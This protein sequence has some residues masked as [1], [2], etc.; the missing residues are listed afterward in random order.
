MLEVPT[1]TFFDQ[2]CR[3]CLNIQTV[4]A[5]KCTCCSFNS[6][7]PGRLGGSHVKA[8]KERKVGLRGFMGS[9]ECSICL[10]PWSHFLI[11]MSE[12]HGVSTLVKS[13]SIFCDCPFSFFRPKPKIFTPIKKSFWP[14]Q[15]IYWCSNRE[16][17]RFRSG[18]S[19]YP[20]SE[21][22]VPERHK[23]SLT[24]GRAGDWPRWRKGKKRRQGQRT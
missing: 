18:F 9:L 14:S 19:R 8:W 24:S 21:V 10:K 17:N 20:S 5:L 3:R 1:S 23:A 7:L 16:L 15:T 13:L 12:S 6:G 22:S 2:W 11:T 4:N